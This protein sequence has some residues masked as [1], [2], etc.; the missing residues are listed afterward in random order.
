MNVINIVMRSRRTAILVVFI[1][2]VLNE[3]RYTFLIHNRLQSFDLDDSFRQIQIQNQEKQKKQEQEVPLSSSSSRDDGEEPSIVNE[4]IH[5]AF[6]GLGH[7]LHRSASAYHLA[8]DLNLSSKSRLHDAVTDRSFITHLRFHWE[9]CLDTNG[10]KE[11]NEEYNVFRYL[12]GEDVWKINHYDDGPGNNINSSRNNGS[13]NTNYRP[14]KRNMIIIRNDIPGYISGQ[15]LKNLQIPIH[16]TPNNLRKLNEYNIILDKLMNSDVEFYR[17][18]V[19][20]YRFR[21]ELRDFQHRHKWNERSLVLGLHLRAGNGEKA[22]FVESGR[23]ASLML[24]ENGTSHDDDDDDEV[25]LTSRL[26]KLIK[27]VINRFSKR[28]VQYQNQY[29]ES[30]NNL[31]PLLFIATDTAHLIPLVK[32]SISTLYAMSKN[33]K[34]IYNH[35]FINNTDSRN[36]NPAYHHGMLLRPEI[37]TWPQYRLP[38]YSGVGFD[39]LQ[40]KGDS[41]LEGWKGSISD[42]LLLSEVDVLLAAKRSTFTQSLPMTLGFGRNQNQNN[43]NNWHDNENLDGTIHNNSKQFSFC[44]VSE[45]DATR[46][47]CATDVR[48]WLFRGED[49]VEDGRNRTSNTSIWTSSIPTTS[50]LKN[51]QN[52]MEVAHKVTVLLPEIAKP[53]E[54]E[55]TR[56]FLRRENSN[57]DLSQSMLNAGNTREHIFRYGQTKIY[58]KYRDVHT[59]TSVSNSSWNIVC[60]NM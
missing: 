3:F 39:A 20:N 36:T 28:R 37:I 50:K 57:N 52:N 42:I 56:A 35:T 29:Q 5:R 15:V 2:L 45:S 59:P 49:N 8:R 4:I 44:E 19:S 58:K 7:R 26:V 33:N 22:H 40:G 10:S 51:Q 9:S 25:V 54:F 21:S 46:V 30:N 27:M 24:Y 23:A 31:P 38:K 11:E 17:R 43:E 32:Q 13:N 55:Q 34:E 48:S 16:K 12:F 18:L 6:F 14:G 53:D 47:T 1:V 41:C 60:N